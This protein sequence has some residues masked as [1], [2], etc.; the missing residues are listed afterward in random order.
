MNKLNKSDLFSIYD[1]VIIVTGGYGHIGKQVVLDLLKCGAKVQCVGRSMN[2]LESFK[3]T[4][5][6]EL[7]DNLTLW[8][9]DLNDEESV[10]I[11]FEKIERKF[12]KI[13]GLFNN[14][15]AI[16]NRGINL[17]LSIQP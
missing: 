5:A 4:M 7:H 14:A 15:A 12:I 8:D 2:K 3:N 13:D 16:N 9:V 10:R 11:L 1:Q 6:D 17:D